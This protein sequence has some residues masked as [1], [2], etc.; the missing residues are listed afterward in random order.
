[1]DSAMASSKRGE[2]GENIAGDRRSDRRYEMQLELR[3]RLLHRRK[4]QD[5]GAG[6]TIDLSSGG[7]AF[8][9]GRKLPLGL[10]IELSVAWP[11]LLQRVAPMQLVISG[12]IVRS[13][14]ART[15]MRIHQHEFRTA[16][17]PPDQRSPSISGNPAT[18]ATTGMPRFS[19]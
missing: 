15:A 3:W 12:L 19:S 8:E 7:V 4:V 6:H 1:M 9:V 2:R 18:R 14:S 10:K 13:D 16:G 17:T 5:A 11:V